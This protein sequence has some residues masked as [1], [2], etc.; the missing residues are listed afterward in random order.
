MWLIQVEGVEG[1]G[2]CSRGKH[3]MQS[4]FEKVDRGSFHGKTVEITLKN[5]LL[6]I[7]NLKS[8]LFQAHNILL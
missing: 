3:F 1:E 8:K 7:K 4:Q 2:A 5:I 6:S